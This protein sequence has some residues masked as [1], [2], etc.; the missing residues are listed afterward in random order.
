L[1]TELYMDAIAKNISDVKKNATFAVNSKG[2]N[3]PINCS[4]IAT[5]PEP[6]VR[7]YFGLLLQKP[8]LKELFETICGIRIEGS[9]T[10]GKQFK[11]YD[12]LPFDDTF[13]KTLKRKYHS[14]PN[15]FK[16]KEYNTNHNQTSLHNPV[17]PQTPPI[18][19]D[20]ITTTEL[21]DVDSITQ[22]VSKCIS[23]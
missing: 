21:V 22:S 10:E 13:L 7:N 18:N 14:I 16:I 4:F 19:D 17:V 9:K 15:N 6:N 23:V 1:E 2:Y 20:K 3:L 12:E 5:F 8:K 11:I